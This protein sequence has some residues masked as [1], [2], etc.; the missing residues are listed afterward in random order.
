[1]E[2][3][4]FVCDCYSP[5]HQFIVDYDLDTEEEPYVYI[6][7]RKNSY[8]NIFQR[9][10]RAIKYILKT[11]EADYNEVMLGTDKTNELIEVLRKKIS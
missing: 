1:M 5:E 2:R 7:I 6:S 11:G 4:H 8:G 3:T 10:W 9:I